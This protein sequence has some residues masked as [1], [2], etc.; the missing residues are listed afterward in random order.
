[1]Q[2]GV[3]LDQEKKEDAEEIFPVE[4]R[5]WR[6]TRKRMKRESNIF[7]LFYIPGTVSS[8]IESSKTQ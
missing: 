2:R 7:K 6:K 5:A 4:A 8:T 3:V 1:M